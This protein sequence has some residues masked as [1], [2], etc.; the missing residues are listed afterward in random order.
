MGPIQTKNLEHWKQGPTRLSGW[1]VSPFMP[2]SKN[3][4]TQ[5]QLKS[6][7]SQPSAV[8]LNH[9]R[10]CWNSTEFSHT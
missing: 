3:W 6:V 5:C 10:H 7:Y 8:T 2:T 9:N 4:P 1:F